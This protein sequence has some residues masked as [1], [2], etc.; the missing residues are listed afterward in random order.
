M[1]IPIQIVIKI[2]IGIVNNSTITPK[3]VSI[4]SGI[5]AM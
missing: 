1:D 2:N 3:A 4:F 5:I